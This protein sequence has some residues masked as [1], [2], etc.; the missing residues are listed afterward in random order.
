[1]EVQRKNSDR[2]NPDQAPPRWL[3]VDPLAFVRCALNTVDCG[4]EYKTACYETVRE[5]LHC[6]FKL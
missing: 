5:C 6:E 2:K 1:M 4:T 3:M